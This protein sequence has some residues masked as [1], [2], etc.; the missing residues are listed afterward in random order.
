MLPCGEQVSHIV[1]SDEDTK[2]FQLIKSCLSFL[3]FFGVAQ[4]AF[5]FS[6]SITILFKEVFGDSS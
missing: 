1:G 4:Q 5:E 6:N 3:S 2:S